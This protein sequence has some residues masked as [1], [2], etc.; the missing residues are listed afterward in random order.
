MED[1]MTDTYTATD[2]I[3]TAPRKT[4]RHFWRGNIFE[5]VAALRFRD[6]EIYD[7]WL[8]ERDTIA[9]TVAL[10]R[11]S[12]R[13]LARIGMHRATLPLDIEDL[14]EFSARNREITEEIIRIVE[15]GD[16]PEKPRHIPHQIAAE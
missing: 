16:A 4:P 1:D 3:E 7:D 12:D 11:L 10:S 9:I 8:E 2:R 14:K 5:T 6:K 13:Q 15:T